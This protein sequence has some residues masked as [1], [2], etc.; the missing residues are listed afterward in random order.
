MLK[1]KGT[2]VFPPAIFDLLN[3]QNLVQDYV[4]EAFRNAIDGDG[5]KIPVLLNDGIERHVAKR[6]LEHEFQSVLRVIPDI[7]FIA[8]AI[9]DA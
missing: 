3:K 1:F 9:G 2:T 5:I 7:I 4:V 6:N 8:P